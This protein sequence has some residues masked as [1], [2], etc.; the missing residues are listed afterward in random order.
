[1]DLFFVRDT[2]GD[3]A[4]NLQLFSLIQAFKYWNEVNE[5]RSK[6]ET[7]S[8]KLL[9]YYVFIIAC[10]GLSLT[11]LLGQNYSKGAKSIPNPGELLADI[12]N[13][14][15]DFSKKRKKII[16]KRFD[17][18]ISI[19]NKCRH[20]GITKDRATHSIVA[21]ITFD[22]VSK[23]LKT[24]LLIWDNIIAIFKK[25]PNNLL[26]DFEPHGIQSIVEDILRNGSYEFRD[27]LV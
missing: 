26:D 14:N 18:F 12:F 4:S 21:G 10:L 13:Q 16:N 19:Y 6:S 15:K 7:N 2:S 23:S 17:E 11:Q 1:M 27:K 25:D 5:M 20:F 8:S 22:E 24:T 9:E 3:T